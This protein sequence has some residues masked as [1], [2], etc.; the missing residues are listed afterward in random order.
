M[1]GER[2]MSGTERAEPRVML[3]AIALATDLPVPARIS[4]HDGI[5]SMSFDR[6]TDGRAWSE[7]L[8][9]RTET[10]TRNGVQYLNEGIIIWRGWSVQLHAS[11][12]ND[13]LDADTRAA[14][15][16]IASEDTP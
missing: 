11:T 15:N 1:G 7:R 8:G 2:A 10:V 5:W 12:P 16:D 13:T 3:A 9:G 14:L 4:H 6:L